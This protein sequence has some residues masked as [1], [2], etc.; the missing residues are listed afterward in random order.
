MDVELP[1]LS[2]VAAARIVGALPATRVVI[3]TTF[4]RDDYVFEGIKAGARGFLLK[5]TPADGLL[6]TTRRVHAGEAAI[7]PELAPCLIA[8]FGRRGTDAPAYE[9]L[10]DRERDVLRLLAAGLSNKEIARD[11][12][13]ADGTV[14][15][16]VST[17]LDK[18]RAA[19]RTQAALLARDRRLI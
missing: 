14:K 2:G 16:H 1:K 12:G 18:L 11:L 4:G 7:Q 9:P 6:A 10:T 15:N 8:E 13:L 3:L 17:V 19:N 5:E